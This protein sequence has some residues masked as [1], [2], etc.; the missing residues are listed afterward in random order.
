MSGTISQR[1]SLIGP[2]GAGKTTVGMGLSSALNY[3]FIDMDKEIE[4]STGAEVSL[5]F[6]KEGE[7]GFRKREKRLL[8]GLLTKTSIVISTGGGIISDHSNRE[9]L[10]KTTTVIY[11]QCDPMTSLSRTRSDRKRP[12]LQNSDPLSKL[13]ELF[14]VRENFYSETAHHTINVDNL[15]SKAVLTKILKTLQNGNS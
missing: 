12:L 11:L 7:A 5:I 1:Y 13:E 9:I 2:M 10:K 6:E 8:E 15:S 14:K 4:R 3:K